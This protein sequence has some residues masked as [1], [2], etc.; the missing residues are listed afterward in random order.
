MVIGLLWLLLAAALLF[1][2]FTSPP[3]VEIKWETAT[4]QNTAG[5]YIYRATTPEGEFEIVNGDNLINSQGNPVSGANYT[6]VDDHV[7]AGQT[8]YYILEEV[9]NDSS[10]NRYEEDMFAYEIPKISWW[11]VILTAASVII[12]LA[13]L[14]TGLKEERNL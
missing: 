6:Y 4:E 8:Y 9:E 1:Y 7:V 2:Q 14:I 10:R 12:G 5:F 3:K 11:A 13:L